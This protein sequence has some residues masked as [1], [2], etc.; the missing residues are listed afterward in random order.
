ML[1]RNGHPYRSRLGWRI[2][3][4]VALMVSVAEIVRFGVDANSEYTDYRDKAAQ[5]SKAIAV[6]AVD[7]IREAV[8]ASD[9]ETVNQELSAIV[10]DTGID[11][12]YIQAFGKTSYLQTDNKSFSSLKVRQAI[13]DF[14]E[15]GQEIFLG[16]LVLV[17]G[18]DEAHE[19]FLKEVVSSA[20]ITLIELSLLVMALLYVVRHFLV[21]PIEKI[22][23][24]TGDIA[25][26][27]SKDLLMPPRETDGKH[28]ELDYLIDSINTMTSR[29][30][31]HQTQ[32]ET[33][34][35]ERTRALSKANME[36]LQAQEISHIGSWSADHSGKIHH[37]S[38]KLNQLLRQD[39]GSLAHVSEIL[40][41][42][43]PSDFEKTSIAIYKALGSM[44]SFHCNARLLF[45]GDEVMHV[46]LSGMPDTQGLIHGVLQDI[47]KA[48]EMEIGLRQSAIV[49]ENSGEGIAYTDE[50][51]LIK[52]VNPAFTEITGFHFSDVHGKPLEFL[53]S[54]DT[55]LPFSDYEQWSK[56]RRWQRE[57]LFRR[58]NGKFYPV[59]LTISPVKATTG[60]SHYVAVFSDISAIR[61]SREQLAYLAH[62][63]PL[64]RLPNRLMF[65][66]ELEKALKRA[67]R[68]NNVLAVL[69]IDL[70]RF[71]EVNDSL[72]HTAGDELLV[73]AAGR[74]SDYF[75]ENDVV[76]RLGGDEFVVILE[77]MQDIASSRQVAQKVLEK[78]LRPYLLQGQNCII[79]ASI[80]ISV[81]PQDGKD[82]SGLL[83]AADSAMYMAKEEGRNRLRYYSRELDDSIAEQVDLVTALKAAVQQGALDV[84]YQPKWITKSKEV[85][86]LE[87]LLRWHHPEYG[88]VPPMKIVSL[89]ESYL[90]V[91]ELTAY[92]FRKAIRDVTCL[93]KD[94]DKALSLTINLSQVV[95]NN[96]VAAV[97]LLRDVLEASELEPEMLEID[98]SESVIAENPEGALPGLQALK[99]LGVR[100]ILD[101]F[102]TANTPKGYLKKLPLDGLKI[103]KSFIQD[104]ASDKHDQII[105]RTIIALGQSLGLDVTA[106]GV[107]TEEQR[108]LLVTEECQYAQGFVLAEPLTLAQIKRL[109]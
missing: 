70:D 11:S 29:L 4:L 23:A 108:H 107:E 66:S 61:E 15:S 84:H 45:D 85:V 31:E 8:V 79:S 36:L 80:G 21:H 68:H 89:A 37:S 14:D 41:L 16:E 50:K 78:L 2:A 26:G 67:D 95:L 34:V 62:H 5:R 52:M 92:V 103:D 64:T 25:K 48:T 13:I 71:K 56:E 46:H 1:G 106:E 10:L 75:R 20:L 12:A 74:L 35:E 51:G 30:Y 55:R 94:T 81:Y 17:I 73:A 63:D 58:D 90:I 3:I 19:L 82:A 57:V 104:I 28:D 76:A 42:I 93:R 97:D 38:E 32:L 105:C 49:V 27:E 91:E 53:K 65:Y 18:L 87:A 43:H 100:I 39:G 24:H 9:T 44:R 77:D 7:R 33:M 72:G 98:I 86:G 54:D 6:L 102:G 59:W 109:F 99:D 101:D 40:D 96:A 47:S 83:R 60:I 69:F 88:N 22:A